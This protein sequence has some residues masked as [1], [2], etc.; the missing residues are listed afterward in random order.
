MVET[1]N[2]SG[3]VYFIQD[4]KSLNLKIGCSQ[5]VTNRMKA[6]KTGNPYLKLIVKINVSNMREKEKY[7]H[8]K[9]HQYRIKNTEW[10]EPSC[11]ISLEIIKCQGDDL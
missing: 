7:Y 4:T 10:F 6:L 5:N 3:Y 1:K 11:E 2:R 9:F 8:R